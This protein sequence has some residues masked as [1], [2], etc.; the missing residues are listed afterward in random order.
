M[1]FWNAPKPVDNYQLIACRAALAIQN[2]LDDL[3]D[4]FISEGHEPWR[5]R[6]GLHSGPCHVGNIGS[7]YRLSYSAL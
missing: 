7:G 3:N 6:V 1:A 2:S 5:T 4:R